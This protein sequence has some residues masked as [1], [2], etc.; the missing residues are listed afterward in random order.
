MSVTHR[1]TAISL[2]LVQAL[3]LIA[4]DPSNTRANSLWFGHIGNQAV[5]QLYANNSTSNL[6]VAPGTNIVV[7]TIFGKPGLV[8]SGTYAKSMTIEVILQID[9]VKSVFF[10]TLDI[11]H[12]ETDLLNV[13]DNIT[14]RE[15][16]QSFTTAGNTITVVG[17]RQANNTA[18]SNQAAFNVV[19]PTYQLIFRIGSS[20]LGDATCND[21]EFAFDADKCV[22]EPICEFDISNLITD[23]QIKPPVGPIKGCTDLPSVLSSSAL[24]VATSVVGTPGPPGPPGATGAP[25][26]PGTPGTSGE[27]GCEPLIIWTTQTLYGYECPPP[28]VIVTQFPP[29]N[30]WVHIV[31]YKCIK[32][33]Y[34]DQHC[35][36]FIYCGDAWVAVNDVVGGGEETLTYLNAYDMYTG[37]TDCVSGT[38]WTV[39]VPSGTVVDGAL[40]GVGTV[41]LD[42]YYAKCSVQR[43]AA[44]SGIEWQN[45]DPD[46]L[47]GINLETLVNGGPRPNCC[48][49]PGSGDT[50]D[51]PA[52]NNP[53]VGL[54]APTGVG[55]PGERVTI[56]D[57]V[58][59]VTSTCDPASSL[60]TAPLSYNEPGPE[61]A[62]VVGH[63]YIGEVLQFWWSLCA[64]SQPAGSWWSNWTA[65][66]YAAQVGVEFTRTAPDPECC[67]SPLD[68]PPVSSTAGPSTTVCNN[69]TLWTVIV[70]AED[71]AMEGVVLVGTSTHVYGGNFNWYAVCAV[72][73]PWTPP[74]F[75]NNQVAECLATEFGDEFTRTN[76]DPGCCVETPACP[77]IIYTTT[78]ADIV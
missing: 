60:W 66:C 59:A 56:C 24:I 49:P 70:P 31:T 10:L 36:D 27:D 30:Y 1:V 13:T 14:V 39:A 42:E 57:C 9:F 20:Q 37:L 55:R 62:V 71:P 75:W 35:C 2:K 18:I 50:V 54:T 16:G 23:C 38:I 26:S 48:L 51:E 40:M 32:D 34:G 65:D 67:T 58:A 76:P 19:T 74:Y 63:S 29:C 15:T 43:P 47:A 77:G 17:I 8:G 4:P 46:V 7:G 52:N 45:I 6:S 3:P 69:G 78:T 28:R 25:G 11:D 73:Q 22:C 41:S 64:T 53:C 12:D 21:E 68:C 72:E 33:H 44:V 5:Y 61:G